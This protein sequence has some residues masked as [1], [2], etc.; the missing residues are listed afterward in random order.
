MFVQLFSLDNIFK[1][2]KKFC[3]GKTNKDDVVSFQYHLDDNILLLHDNISTGLYK[4]SDYEY[5]QIF[6]NKK[7]DIYKANV[8]DRVVHQII[9]DYL[10]SIYESIFISDS[11]SSRKNKGHHKAIIT[12]RYFIKL[13]S[14]GGK[15]GCFV[16]KC[17]VK[18][19]FDNID[20]NILFRIIKGKTHCPKVLSI[21]RE[22][23][24]SFNTRDADGQSIDGKGIPLGNITSQIFANIYLNALDQYVKREL[25]CR[26]YLRYNDDVAIVSNNEEELRLFRDEM[27][28]F[29][30]NKLNLIIPYEKTSIKKVSWGIDF[31]GYIILPNAVVLRDK[32]KAKMYSKIDKSNITS[33]LGILKHCNA[34]NLRLKTISMVY[35][36][37]A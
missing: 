22:I 24:D 16:L 9:Y 2:W 1:A 29:A 11:Y 14:D 30:R 13:A 28:N 12:L 7:R 19:Y 20:H 23:I 32:T 27:I 33:Y 8:R 10:V 35:K 18:K 3:S 17:D 36:G 31:L 34:Y 6:D 26:F 15:R 37:K 21:I 25:R 4:H 5:F